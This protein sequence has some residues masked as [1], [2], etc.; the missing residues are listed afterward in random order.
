MMPK[1]KTFIK[2]GQLWGSTKSQLS[3]QSS[4]SLKNFLLLSAKLAEQQGS[5]SQSTS[6]AGT[7]LQS[8]QMQLN[9]CTIDVIS[10]V[11]LQ[12][13]WVLAPERAVS[14]S[15]SLVDKI[16][17]TRRTIRP[18]TLCSATN[19]PGFAICYCL[20]GFHW[21]IVFCLWLDDSR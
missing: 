13:H 1:T 8:I 12:C 15:I 21:A 3:A 4:T 10:S 6:A 19:C 11:W 2:Y 14:Q 5:P 7:S 18:L 16:H 17:R 20:P 9:K